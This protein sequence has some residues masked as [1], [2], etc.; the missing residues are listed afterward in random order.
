MMGLLPCVTLLVPRS[1][2]VPP[3]PGWPELV[4]TVMPGARP[5]MMSCVLR[6]GR[7]SISFAPMAAVALPTSFL[8]DSAAVPV[9]TTASSESAAGRSWKSAVTV[10][11]APS[12]TC[13]DDAP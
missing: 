10:S 2:M 4:S 9:T 12:V 6:T 5:A 13:R 7:A 8:R 1:R 11:V 3:A